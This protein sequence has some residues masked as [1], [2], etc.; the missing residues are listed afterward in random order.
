M[1]LRRLGR[2][3]RARSLYLGDLHGRGQRTGHKIENLPVQHSHAADV[4]DEHVL[5]SKLFSSTT[6]CFR[7][8]RHS[9][10]SDVP[11]SD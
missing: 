5:S 11:L 8:K 3:L 9:K 1:R 4:S 10:P 6:G 7:G 2:L